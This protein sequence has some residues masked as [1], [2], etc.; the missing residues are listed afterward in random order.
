ME[1]RTIPLNSVPS[2]NS[3]IEY[4]DQENFVTKHRRTPSDASSKA[5]S[6][7]TNSTASHSPNT[8]NMLKHKNEKNLQTEGSIVSFQSSQLS[9]TESERSMKQGHSHSH[10][11]LNGSAYSSVHSSQQ[12]LPPMPR[13]QYHLATYDPLA[14]HKRTS[15]FASSISGIK[16][17]DIM[18]SQQFEMPASQSSCLP[19]QRSYGYRHHTPLSISGSEMEGRPPSEVG[20]YPVTVGLGDQPTVCRVIQA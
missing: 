7:R 19:S 13:N 2:I 16:E 1:K 3:K 10:T 11:R 15:S 20:I 18:S 5:S 12:S 17:E 4:I 14:H 8:M 9:Q 6:Y